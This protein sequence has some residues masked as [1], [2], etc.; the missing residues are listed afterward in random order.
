MLNQISC[1]RKEISLDST[2]L[3]YQSTKLIKIISKTGEHS[4]ISQIL[5]CFMNSLRVTMEVG[6]K[7]HEKILSSCHMLG[8]LTISR[9]LLTDA[10]ACDPDLEALSM[11]TRT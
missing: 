1:N 11:D 4:R 5:N 7:A 10:L 3:G 2:Y 6:S 8:C 9:G